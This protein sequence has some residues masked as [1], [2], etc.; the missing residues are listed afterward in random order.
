LFQMRHALF[1]LCDLGFD[2]TQLFLGLF[3]LQL[4]V[5]NYVVQISGT[6]PI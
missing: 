1:A 2:E 6:L 5:N 3:I 4:R